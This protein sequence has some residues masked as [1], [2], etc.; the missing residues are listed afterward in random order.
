LVVRRPLLVIASWI[1]FAGALALIFPPLPVQAA[2]QEQKPLPDD[3]PTVV[4]SQEMQ[5]AFHEGGGGSQAMVV[6][7]DE[8]GLTPGDENVYRKLVEKL[9]QDQQEK[10]SVQD[11]LK[12]PEMRDV[13]A[14]K[15]GKAITLP[16]GFPDGAMAPS[17]LAAFHHVKEIAKEV[18]AGTTLR[19]YLSGPVATIADITAL[20]EHDERFITIATVTGLLLILFIIYRNVVTMFVPLAN[21]GASIGTTQ[22]VLSGLVGAGLPFNLESMIL[23]TAVMLGA[24]TDYAVFLISRYHDYVRHGQHSDQAVKNAMMSIGKVITASAATVAVTF[25]AMVFTKLQVFSAVGPA[26]A[27]AIFVA[28]ASAVTLLPALMV[29][30]GRRGWIKPR[31]ELTTRMWR[32]TGTRVVRRPRI[33]LVGSLLVL[34]AL[35][36]CTSVMRFNYDD[37]KTM[38][39]SVD[40]SKGYDA[41]TRHYP[42]NAMTPM[43]LFVQSSHDLRTPKALADLEQ[44]AA[45]VSEVPGVI[46]VRGL[47]RPNGERLEQMKLSW[48][49]GEVGDKLDEASGQ[50]ANHGDDLDKLV[51]GSN[52][53]ADALAQLRDEVTGAVSSLSGVVGAL[54][55]MEQMLGG[56][57]AIAALEQGATYTGQM[58]SLGDNLGASTA[59]AQDTAQWAGPMVRALNDSPE[60]DADPGCVRSRAGLAALV[61]A[62]NDGTLNSLK[63]MAY[64]LQSAQKAA[65]IG[66]TLDSVQQTL[67][68]ASGALKTIKTLQ[69][70]MAQAQQG[71]NAL[72]DGSRAIAGGVKQLV[73][74]TRKLGSGLNEASQ[75]LLGMKR[76]AEAPSMA[77]FNLPPQITTRDEFKKGAQIFLSPDG[78]AARYL[79]QSSLNPFSTEAMDQI[80]T[81]EKAAR[82]AFPN[83]EL[84]D[85]KVA[86]AGIPSGLRDTRDYYNSDIGFIVIATIL[87]VFLI[88][89][90]LLR[91]IVAPLYLIGSVLLS[92]LS[93][94][95]LGVLVFQFLL[96]QN[97]HWSLPGLSFILLVAIGAD[98]NMLLI[99]RIR[100]ESP[101]GV[102]VGVIRTVGSTGGVITSA[103][104]IFAASMFGLMSA[105]IYTLVEAGFILGMGILIDTFLVRTITV[106][107]LAAMIGQKN[108]WPSSLG[109]SPAQVLAA[110]AAKQRQLEQISGQ[111]VR[112][113]VLPGHRTRTPMPEPH[114]AGHPNGKPG[115]VERIPNHALPLFDLSGVSQHFTDDLLE[116]Q[117]ASATT[118]GHRNGNRYLGHSL[119]LFGPGAL[120]HAL[121]T[122]T[123]NGNGHRSDSGGNAEQAGD[124]DESLPLFGSGA[125]HSPTANR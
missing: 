26:I 15:D 10:L 68:Q 38:P 16:I 11:V 82:S 106:P 6:L 98:Y 8:R 69:T 55:A 31:R 72:A 50:I 14:S 9:Q 120:S 43:F 105:S 86:V 79:I 32:V 67:S 100:D 91:A 123:T 113:K 81:L 28:L 56:D 92:Y 74:Q 33:H 97:L 88:L 48:Q 58:K 83:T 40:S 115:A 45:R 84:A 73:D 65:T 90:V 78:H 37:L 4:V 20:T 104:L 70:T 27:I 107:A 75:F 12:V 47:T 41:M 108:W 57:K 94:M 122:V 89:V 52:Q 111:L 42:M 77:G 63:I 99:S 118:N 35:A 60:C 51:N 25:S 22:G 62:D 29:L 125:T 110:Y 13:L 54:T 44:M 117:R 7:T 71:S 76:D 46:M 23:M 114:A 19:A 36:S 53:L 124:E 61:A 34:I 59:H 21:I 3:A 39:S 116:P 95:G 1:V 85:A 121:V 64:N 101:H 80:N 17:T 96:G 119:P 112:M 93:A 87:I 18:T 103:G 2:K 109:K 49:A 66:Q 30:V 24:G 5:K 102:R